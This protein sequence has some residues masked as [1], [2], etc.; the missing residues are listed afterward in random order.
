MAGRG[1]GRKVLVIP[2][3]TAPYEQDTAVHLPTDGIWLCTVYYD[4]N[5]GGTGP[6]P[7]GPNSFGTSTADETIYC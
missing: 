2:N 3:L 7:F 4:H 5:S 1:V 6:G